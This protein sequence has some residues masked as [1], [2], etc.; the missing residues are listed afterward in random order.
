MNKITPDL[1]AYQLFHEGSI[2]LSQV[3]ANGIKIDL[4]QVKKS[5]DYI[6]QQIFLI[7]EEIRKSKTYEIWESVYKDKT[8][9]GSRPQLADVLFNHMGYTCTK[10]TPTR[11]PKVDEEV[12]RKIGLPELDSLIRI[13]KFKKLKGTY[14]NGL[15][16]EV[17][18]GYLHP[19]FNLHNLISYR[20]S[21]SSINFQNIPTRHPEF[22]KII[23]SCFVSREN[24]YLVEL[25]FAGI[26]VKTSLAYTKDPNLASYLSDPTKD[27][28]KDTAADCYMLESNQ[29]GKQA[30]Y[31]GKNKFVFPAFYG[32]VY[33][34]CAVGL[35]EALDEFQLKVKKPEDT[36]KECT[37]ILIK[38]H[39]ANK[40]ITEL[41]SCNPK[42]EPKRNTFEWHIKNVEK[43]FWHERF[44]VY[45]KWKYD[46]YDSYVNTGSFKSLTG[47]KF[48]G[49]YKKNEV[50]NYANQATAFHCLL[51]SLIQLQKWLNKNKMKS[52]IVGQ[53]HDSMV[54]D[55]VKSELQDILYKAKKIMTVDLPNHWKWI[56]TKLETETEVSI[57]GTSWYDKKVWIEKRNRWRE[58][59]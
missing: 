38:Q 30:R 43:K 7:N 57:P 17:V 12:I 58:K 18:D 49:L 33:F 16:T 45:T 47:F 37:G 26:E 29:I 35:W 15:L 39:L 20:S 8:N 46:W 1:E 54:L 3:E 52:M 59:K 42:K 48:S 27:M 44:P 32:S 55:V 21:S 22:S 2:A 56:N 6:D 41:G 36:D 34:Q 11:K 4:D 5:N 9:I 14:I 28:H 24:R 31:C 50:L 51:W 23:R 10:F 13:E 19:F 53:I 25:D 40:G